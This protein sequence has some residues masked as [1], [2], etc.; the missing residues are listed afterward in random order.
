M[1]LRR[2]LLI[3]S[4]LTLLIPWLGL[5]FVLELDAAL[6]QQAQ[7]QLQNQAQRMAGAARPLLYEVMA[8]GPDTATVYAGNLSQRLNLDGYADD[9]PG[10]EDAS[11]DRAAPAEPVS[12]QAAVDQDH[13]Y[14]LLQ[15]QRH[16]PR[17]FDPSRPDHRHEQVR[18]AWDN[19]GQ[20]VERIIRTPAPGPVV[21]WLP[22]LAPQPDYRISGVW[23]AH[24]RGY[25]LELRLP[26]PEAGGRFGFAVETG[27]TDVPASG[28]GLEPLPMLVTRLPAVEHRLTP[29]LAPGQ[30]FVVLNPAGW[31]EASALVA[32]TEADL[33]FARLSPLQIVEQISLNGLRSLVRFYQPPPRPWPIDASQQPVDRLP[34]GGL[35]RTGAG[36]GLLV[37]A[38][39]PDGRTLL[40]HQSLDQL[41]TLAGSALGTVIARSTLLVVMLMLVLLG[42]SSWLSWRITRL[43]RAV[44]ASVDDD[45]RIVA[46]LPLSRAG[47]ELGDL[48][49]RFSQMIEQLQG[50]TQYLE[51]FSR[52]LSH[53]LKTPIAIA[54]S[55][56]DNLRHSQP[57]D[58]QQ[59]YLERIRQATD[60][61]SQILQGMSE[62]ARLEQSFDRAEHERF[63]LA[64]VAAQAAGAYQA[65][66]PDHRIGYRG[67]AAG[68]PL[69]GA[70]EMLVQLLDK[71]VDNAR[72]FTPSGGRIE[73]Q[74][75]DLGSAWSLS[76]YN[77]GSQLPDHLSSELF[78]PFV[79]LRAG[80]GEGHLGQGLL[81]VR[82]IAEHH[83][84]RAQARNT[85]DGVVFSV[86]LPKT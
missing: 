36:S 38:P 63:D 71:L 35:V 73:V 81:I 84:G 5:Q 26:R 64:D 22:T 7:G 25:Q 3:A 54:R 79:S 46:A 59:A 47:D 49:R 60:R 28:P 37:S 2:Q 43:Q 30:R 61:L 76:V 33:D 62:A 39:L 86:R 15:V 41:L 8:P 74:L 85:D 42:Y 52:R 18:L 78:S 70:P 68:C 23:Q 1:N 31:V 58:A 24:G 40:L 65:L 13:L 34:E 56:L 10:Y 69:D 55:S 11:S 77:E 80:S 9:W 82:L 72:D 4:L 21:G 32:S 17:Y 6:R 57:N 50:Y 75:D 20:R 27:E 29:Y 14:L 67:P 12:W 83:Q 66:D 44:D 16:A 48:S 53:E 19:N 45:G 51:S